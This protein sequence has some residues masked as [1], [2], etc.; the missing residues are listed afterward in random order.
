[1]LMGVLM[2]RRVLYNNVVSVFWNAFLSTLSHA[3]TIE[4]TGVMDFLNQQVDNLPQPLHEYAADFADSLYRGTR[5]LHEQAA[6][7]GDSW[8]LPEHLRPMVCPPLGTAFVRHE[9][10]LS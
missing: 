1:M 7:F 2:L 9:D 10:A 6:L 8:G 5:P 3:P 4:P